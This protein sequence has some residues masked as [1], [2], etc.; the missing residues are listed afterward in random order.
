MADEVVED[1]EQD[2]D[3]FEWGA[4]PFVRMFT[5]EGATL[6]T[7]VFHDPE[8]AGYSLIPWVLD[9]MG[10][11]ETAEGM[12]V[13]GREIETDVVAPLAAIPKAGLQAVGTV[14]RFF[15]VL[16]IVVGLVAV[17]YVVGVLRL[18]R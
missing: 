13:G 2:E 4:L 7:S 9:S 16:L 12:D 5:S 1:I 18:G 14:S 10:F 15:P 11:V 3:G 17:A 6:Q 8:E